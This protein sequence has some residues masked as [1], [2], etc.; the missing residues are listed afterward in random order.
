MKKIIEYLNNIILAGAGTIATVRYFL[1]ERGVIDNITKILLFLIALAGFM[2]VYF[3][4]K[5][6]AI[7]NLKIKPKTKPE[8][9]VDIALNDDLN[10]Y[11]FLK[12]GKSK[13]KNVWKTLI[14]M[15]RANKFTITGN[16][17]LIALYVIM[18][19]EL[20]VKFGYTF[21]KQTNEFYIRF[22]IY[23]VG[24]I[25][26][27]I[28]TNGFGWE[29]I[30]KWLARVNQNKL[31]KILD[32]LTD[33]SVELKP[34]LVEKS[35]KEAYFLL[36]KIEPFIKE[37]LYQ[38]IKNK[39]DE[40]DLKLKKYKANKIIEEEKRRQE[41]LRLAQ[42]ELNQTPTHHTPPSNNRGLMR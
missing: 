10:K 41:L 40:I 28:A 29:R 18:L 27:L 14:S 31:N 42:Q 39:L 7:D 1:F 36:E 37:K 11:N 9:C 19:D 15:I 12:G 23:T 25:F 34:D 3:G 20:F 6:P 16:F 13:M 33:L 22:G 8:K 26:A 38:E 4:W 5:L 30:E 2:R 35:L 17:S 21:I 32:K 24:F